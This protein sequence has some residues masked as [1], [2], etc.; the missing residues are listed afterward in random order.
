[1]AQG[2]DKIAVFHRHIGPQVIWFSRDREKKANVK[3][4]WLNGREHKK[5]PCM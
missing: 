3:V 1:M 5:R 2:T 4:K